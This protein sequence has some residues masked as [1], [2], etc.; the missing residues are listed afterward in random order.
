MRIIVLFSWQNDLNDETENTFTKF[1]DDT[2]LC[3]EVDMKGGR[4]VLQ[5]E[6]DRLKGWASKNYMK[7]NKDKCKVLHL[8]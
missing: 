6:L 5:R 8:E 1:V 3:G 4:D 7:F 2:K